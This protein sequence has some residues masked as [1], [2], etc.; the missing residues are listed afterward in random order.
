MKYALLFAFA[1]A[2]AF[3]QPP[4]VIQPGS[5]PVSSVVNANFTNLYNGRIGRWSG[6]G[7]PGNFP[8][9]IIGD[10]YVNTS[11]S[12]PVAYF[13]ARATACSA[14]ASGNWQLIGTG[15][16]GGSGTVTSV[17]FSRTNDTNINA[18]ITGNPITTSGTINIALSWAGTLAAARMV[19]AGVHTGD[20][21]TTFPNCTISNAAITAAKMV[22]AGVFTGDVTTTFPAITVAKVNGNTPGGTCTNQFARSLDTSARPTCASVNLALDTAG[23]LAVTHL[24][25]GT[26]ASSTTFWRGDGVWAT[27]AGSGTVTVLGSGNLTTAAFMQGAGTQVS[28]TI[29]P[30]CTLDSSGNAIFTGSLTTG[31]GSGIAGADYMFGGTTPA[32]PANT[33]GW[34]APTTVT[35]AQ[36]YMFPNA[37]AAPHSVFIVGTPASNISPTT[38]KVIPDC[39][40]GYLN[41]TQSTDAFGCAPSL[42]GSTVPGTNTTLSGPSQI[43]ICTSTC[44][45]TVPI[46]SLN[47]QFCVFNDDNVSTV[48]TLAAIGSGARYENTARTAYGTAGTGTLQSGGAVKDFVC[49]VGRDATHYVTVSFNG[50]WT[51]S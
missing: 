5:P 48:I 47:V 19:N 29:C 1:A 31:N 25:T 39:P 3:A 34:L 4:T 43:Y 30:G 11:A 36:G 50:T 14:V 10:I 33:T 32:I 28:Q 45:I 24:N 17:D 26:G 16:G 7:T 22:N 42:P 15:G 13:C 38:T 18:T 21:V 49:I 2:A 20:C 37:V 27:P 8:F 9:S 12:P 41:F 23:N 6:A 40:A 44:T 35:T 46:P 51:A